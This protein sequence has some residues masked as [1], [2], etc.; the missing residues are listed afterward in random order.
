MSAISET[1]SQRTGGG[2][3]SASASVTFPATPVTGSLMVIS[4]AA[5]G[6]AGVQPTT[7]S[8]WT[9]ITGGGSASFIWAAYYR[10]AA[11]SESTTPTIALSASG[12]W[13]MVA[14]N[15]T[16][17]DATAPF[18]V[19]WSG[20]G[21]GTALSTGASGALSNAGNA[22]VTIYFANNNNITYSSFNNSQTLSK[23]QVGGDQ[24]LVHAFVAPGVTT[25][26]TYTVSIDK[27]NSWAAIGVSFKEAANGPMIG[28]A[29][30][31]FTASGTITSAGA[32][33]GSASLAF[34]A[35]ATAYL[36]GG[37]I[38]DADLSFTASGSLSALTNMVPL[39][40]DSSLSFTASGTLYGRPPWGGI[41]FR[42]KWGAFYDARTKL[43]NKIYSRT[44]VLADTLNTVLDPSFENGQLGW[45]TQWDAG[46]SVGVVSFAQ[47][48]S[49]CAIHAGSTA[50]QNARVTNDGKLLVPTSRKI[51]AAVSFRNA[52]AN[53]TSIGGV[54]VIWYDAANAFISITEGAVLSQAITSGKWVQTRYAALAPINAIYG[55]LSVVVNNHT[56]GTWYADSCSA[57]TGAA[58]IGGSGELP[59]S[60]V[61]SIS[62]RWSGLSI[63]YTVPTVGSP[64][65][66][67]ISVSAATLYAGDLVVSYN[68]SSAVINQTRS[69]TVVYYLWYIDPTYLGGSK[70]LNIS[71]DPNSLANSA[72][73]IWVG[74]VSSVVPALGVTGGGGGDAGGGC[75]DI[76]MWV[77]EHR[78]LMQI[79]LDD[80]LDCPVYGEEPYIEQRRVRKNTVSVQP[81]IRIVSACGA[82]V[83]ASET[84]PMTL[85]NGDTVQMPEMFGEEVLIDDDGRL[86]WDVVVACYPV[87]RRPVMHVNVSDTCYF[88]GV[89]GLMRI[90]THNIYAKP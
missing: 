31:S 3:T 57:A 35:Q 44:K 9:K 62:S 15:Y 30:F 88:A 85:R 76:A 63:T 21:S 40:T 2:A 32:F 20:S 6:Q 7:P 47:G 69:T 74:Q 59:P 82:E 24:D 23:E 28:D 54:G 1:T 60:T 83:V 70:T 29:G 65:A 75:V 26:K 71:T 46:W 55:K 81:C 17:A 36:P 49:N 39:G 78:Q 14:T 42:M 45:T 8:G 4:V 5:T 16:G 61:G 43:L 22:V 41:L 68:A 33:S 86:F 79:E 10:V 48:G 90:A 77:D 72:D 19:S 12:S 34:T 37:I 84:T 25:T 67:T 52:S 27:S 13:T 51:V 38:G 66:V 56:S 89:D 87:G 58:S 80:E 50:N 53:S 64:A 18:D 11:A 73:V